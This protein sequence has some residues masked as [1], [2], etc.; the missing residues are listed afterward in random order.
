VG[1]GAVEPC[2]GVLPVPGELG[3]VARNGV[4]PSREVR[5]GI[6]HAV[7]ELA[8]TDPID[9]LRDDFPN[10]TVRLHTGWSHE[11]LARVKSGSLDAAVILLFER[12]NAPTGV[13]A[14]ALAG[15]HLAVAAPHSWRPRRCR[16]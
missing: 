13:T 6:A 9:R 3:A 16:P 4:G 12:E 11:L 1:R 8:V 10:A 2:R 14:H 5:I 7:N 15:E